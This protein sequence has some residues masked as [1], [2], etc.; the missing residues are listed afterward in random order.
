MLDSLE[1]TGRAATHV[2][3]FSD[4]PC[5]LH[6]RA[7]QA[8]L[9][10]RAAAAD[11]GINLTVVSGFR[12]FT[13]QVRIW[14]EK[15]SG[16]RPLLDRHGAPLARAGLS[17]DELVDAILLWSALPGASR[18][19]WGSELDLMD[20]AAI[21]QGM[22]AQ[23]VP[24]E[25][26]RG[27]HFARLDAWLSA[28]MDRF[29]FFRP[30]AQDRGGVQPEP[31]HVSFAEVSVPALR[32]L[33]VERLREAILATDIPGRQSVLDRLPQLHARYVTNVE[34]P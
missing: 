4:P 19:H 25:F 22:T 34:S 14:S 12:D 18:H 23:L 26:V 6:P 15:F 9:A 33:S 10:M 16:A 32:E 28:N 20:A 13:R 17:E 7:A 5:T 30:Y 3:K 24:G 29:G 1:L 2:Q 21:P 31:W 27:G 8:L 11:Q